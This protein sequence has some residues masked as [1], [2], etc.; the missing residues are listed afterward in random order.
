MAP[1]VQQW[2]PC[3]GK[4]KNRIVVVHGTGYLSQGMWGQNTTFRS[5]CRDCRFWKPNS[6]HQACAANSF[7]LESPGCSLSN[8]F[9]RGMLSRDQSLAVSW[10]CL[11]SVSLI[12]LGVHP[13]LS[14]L[15]PPLPSFWILICLLIFQIFRLLLTKCLSLRSYLGVPSVTQVQGP[16]CFM[17]IPNIGRKPITFWTVCYILGIWPQSAFSLPTL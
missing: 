3:S 7:T 2:L 4:A 1:V 14:F 8:T 10:G 9:F 15:L 11:T 6:G 17:Q 5:C 13:F 12:Y 16:S